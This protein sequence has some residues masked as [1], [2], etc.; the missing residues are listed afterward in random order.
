MRLAVSNIA[1]SYGDRTRAYAILRAHGFTGLEIAPGL[2]FADEPD[3]FAPSEAA[4]RERV[5][6]L[7]GFG[8]QLVSMQSLLFGVEGADLFGPESGR[9]RFEEGTARAI[10]L[11][12]RLG[13]ANLVVGSPRQRV[14]PP[15]LG[16]EAVL[17]TA[18]ETF[19]K[20]GD[21]AEAQ[22]AS[23]ALEPNAVAYG[24][25]F[26]TT[27]PETIAVVRAVDHPAVTFNFDVGALHMTDAFENVAAFARDY[28]PHL[29]HV[30]VSSPHLAPAPASEAE[31][32]PVIDALKAIG[33]RRA[34]SIEMKAVEDQLATLEACVAR[35]AAVAGG[36]C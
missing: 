20:L 15:G 1:W 21:L 3:S 12:G 5:T 8:L 17:V 18:R 2:L 23:L 28:A 36:A 4:V 10:A 35:L 32:R 24:A 11:A 22:G 26:M 6:E 25:N 30:H 33:F 34:V 29:S 31:A 19:R 9:A 16:A 27:F 7:G 14:I 13:V